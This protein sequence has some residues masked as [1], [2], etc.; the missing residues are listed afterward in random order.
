[1]FLWI[2]SPYN[3][4][5]PIFPNAKISFFRTRLSRIIYLFK[6]LCRRFCVSSVFALLVQAWFNMSTLFYLTVL[7]CLP[8]FTQNQAVA[9]QACCCADK[10]NVTTMRTPCLVT[11]VAFFNTVSGWKTIWGENLNNNNRVEVSH[12]SVLPTYPP[13]TNCDRI[14]YLDLEGGISLTQVKM[15]LNAE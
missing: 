9:F 14:M 1:L 2:T 7:D 12:V 4:L 8:H 15:N 11:A 13:H 6:I 10:W 3:H 5:F